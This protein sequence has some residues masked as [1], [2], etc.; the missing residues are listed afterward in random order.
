MNKHEF[1]DAIA[2]LAQRI[3]SASDT[4]ENHGEG[5]TTQ[6]IL[7]AEGAIVSMLDLQDDLVKELSELIGRDETISSLAHLNSGSY[8]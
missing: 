2:D 3:E 4:F 7:E 5:W 8:Q 6:R 1:I